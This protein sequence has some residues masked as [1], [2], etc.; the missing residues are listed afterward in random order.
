MRDRRQ[1]EL[2]RYGGGLEGLL[3]GETAISRIDGEGGRLWYRSLPLERLAAERSFEEV[4]HLLLHGTLPDEAALR[5]WSDELK[6]WRRP[7]RAALEAL[8]RVP[9]RSHPLAKYRTMLTV[10]GCL[11][12]HADERS[13]DPDYSRPARILGWSATLAAAAIRHLSGE[14]PVDPP[15]EGSHAEG[16]LHRVLGRAP[17]RVESRA[18]E[19]SLIAQAEHG[20]HAAAL[21]ALTVYSTGADLGSAVLAGMGALSGVRHGGA[22]QLAFELM[23]P[24]QNAQQA[25][26]RAREALARKE[27]IPGFGHR[28]YRCPDPRVAVLLPHAATL[29]RATDQSFRLEVFEALQR[30]VEAALGPRG[31]FANVDAVTG[32]V[33]HPL[34]LPPSAFPI[35]FCLAIQTGWMAHCAEYL[36]EGKMIEPGAVYVG[37]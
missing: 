26:A 20:I 13:D 4:S 19:V 16:F 17:E 12:P 6:C 5:R 15:E 24:L 14:E 27:R 36:P 7:P 30:E 35:P 25:R 29:L 32:L 2:Q 3:A 1:I 21:A 10:A 22:N 31:I 8:R 37:E 34:G 11:A 9:A 28:V 18:F 23:A 33:Y